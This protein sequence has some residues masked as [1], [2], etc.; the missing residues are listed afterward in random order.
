[1]DSQPRSIQ[2]D[3]AGKFAYVPNLASN[4][5]EVFSIGAMGV[6]TAA[7]KVRTRPQAAAIAFSGGTT[8]VTY[9]PKFAYVANYDSGDVSA[10]TV[11]P[12]AE[13]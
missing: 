3:P 5:V 2:V 4:E 13:R 8:A 9:T 6:L 12:I 10:Y 7:G 1:M 11:D